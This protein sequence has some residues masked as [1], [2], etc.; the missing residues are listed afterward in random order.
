MLF[1][2]QHAMKSSIMS[3]KPQTPLPS[4]PW[5]HHKVN[6]KGRGMISSLDVVLKKNVCWELSHYRRASMLRRHGTWHLNISNWGKKPQ[7]LR[8]RRKKHMEEDFFIWH[9]IL[10]PPCVPGTPFG[11][12]VSELLG[13][14]IG[15]VLCEWRDWDGLRRFIITIFSHKTGSESWQE[16]WKVIGVKCHDQV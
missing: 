14:S 3:W 5:K 9:A 7:L 10:S 2:K 8:R 11:I 4:P 1:W 16:R 12:C 6:V 13:N 15:D